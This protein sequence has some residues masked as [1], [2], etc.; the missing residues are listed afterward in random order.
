[1]SRRLLIAA[2]P[3]EWRAALTQ[4][5]VLAEFR[6][7]RWVGGS[8]VGELHM[9]RV[10]RGMRALRA[11]LVEI[12]LARP[13]YLSLDDAASKPASARSTVA[14]VHAAPIKSPSTAIARLGTAAIPPKQI[15]AVST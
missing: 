10:V 7:V 4:D 9:G 5:G 15:R 3:G 6:L 11:V 14:R 12:G 2:T 1:M 13:A 8:R